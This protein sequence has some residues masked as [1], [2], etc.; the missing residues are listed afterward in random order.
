MNP[1]GETTAQTAAAAPTAALSDAEVVARVRA[2]ERALFEVLLRR[3]DRRV[4]RTARAILRDEDEVEDAMQQTW[5]QVY[6]HLAEFQG[7]AA[8]STWLVRIAANEALQRLRKRG[9]LAP[10]PTSRDEEET[11]MSPG[12]NPEERAAAREAIRLL[13]HAV[14]ALPP[15]HRL[16][17]MLREVEGL[18]TA[19]TAAALGIAEDAAKVRLHRAR[20]VLRKTLEE[21]VVGAAEEAF[22]F[23]APRCN[24]VVAGVMEAIARLEPGAA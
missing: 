10:V 21:T 18:S 4:Y 13:E 20:A 7:N 19:E 14:D 11:M 12:A 9:P 23:H 1:L 16:V 5:I 22:P 17:F 6:L 24:R 8:F 3:H 2:G 15:H